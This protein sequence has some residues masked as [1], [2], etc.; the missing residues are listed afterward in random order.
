[1]ARILVEGSCRSEVDRKIGEPLCRRD[2]RRST[3]SLKRV[4]VEMILGARSLLSNV[5][6]RMGLGSELS[7]EF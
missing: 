7:A 5:R 2:R 4:W 1:M 6:R 3:F